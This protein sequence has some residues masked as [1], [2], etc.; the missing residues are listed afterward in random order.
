[1]KKKMLEEEEK[2]AQDLL[3]FGMSTGINEPQN[4]DSKVF[5]K[6][7]KLVNYN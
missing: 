7:K 3:N 2:M 1:M 5:K 4:S 6:A